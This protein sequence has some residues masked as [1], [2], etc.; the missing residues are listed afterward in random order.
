MVELGV[1]LNWKTFAKLFILVIN[2]SHNEER[3]FSLP[4][5]LLLYSLEQEESICFGVL[6]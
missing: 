4:Y 6:E 3:F 2:N 5:F 1:K